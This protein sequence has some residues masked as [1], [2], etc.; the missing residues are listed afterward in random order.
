MTIIKTKEKVNDLNLSAIAL[1]EINEGKRTLRFKNTL[2]KR[3]FKT[4]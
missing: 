2:S 1:T 3:D 4:N